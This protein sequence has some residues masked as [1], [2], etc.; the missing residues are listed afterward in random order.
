V[1]LLQRH[2]AARVQLP[3]A[4]HRP[5][6][7]RTTLRTTGTKKA[8]SR[9]VLAAGGLRL[10]RSHRLRWDGS[11]RL[12]QREF[13]CVSFA[14]ADPLL[15]VQLKP[16]CQPWPFG[17]PTRRA[18]CETA[19]CMRTSSSRIRG[20]R[21][22]ASELALFEACAS[23][24]TQ[25]MASQQ[26]NSARSNTHR[27]YSFLVPVVAASFDGVPGRWRASGSCTRGPQCL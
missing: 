12:E 24:P 10:L 25:P 19:G 18:T 13:H 9:W 1:P 22:H 6:R 26:A 8:I 17:S 27:P 4:R 3:E 21:T 23:R 11:R 5:V 20:R 7:R 15:L 2:W 16:L 14:A